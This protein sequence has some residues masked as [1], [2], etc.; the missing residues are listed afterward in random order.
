MPDTA[1]RAIF[2]SIQKYTTN[3]DEKQDCGIDLYAD[4]HDSDREQLDKLAFSLQNPGKVSAKEAQS[5][6]SMKG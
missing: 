6:Y 4:F 1:Q 3:T 5:R 2:L